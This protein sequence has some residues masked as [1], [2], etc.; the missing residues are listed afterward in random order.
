MTHLLHWLRYVHVE[1]YNTDTY[2]LTEY[3]TPY[4]YAQ[5]IVMHISCTR[6]QILLHVQELLYIIF[7]YLGIIPYVEYEILISLL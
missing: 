3:T 7:G 4:P 6:I 5:H 1:H 2:L